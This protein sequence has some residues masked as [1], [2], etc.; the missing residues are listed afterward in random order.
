[1]Q[2]LVIACYRAR[3]GKTE[4]LRELMRTHV[5]RLRAEGLATDRRPIIGQ[6][7]DGTFVEVFEWA[8]D[9]AIQ[10]A[11]ENAAVLAMWGEFEAI[12]DYVP[13]GEVPGAQDLFTGLEPVDFDAG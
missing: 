11:H 12:C 6:A 5:A 3:P 4:A 10:K 1:M 9:D 7:S 8:S 13:V 2:K